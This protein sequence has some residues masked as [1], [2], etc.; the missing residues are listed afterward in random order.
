[1]CIDMSSNISEGPDHTIKLEYNANGEKLIKI[2]ETLSNKSIL[3]TT[4]SSEGG[5]LNQRLLKSERSAR[6]YADNFVEHEGL[7]PR[8]GV[9][10]DI[11]L[12]KRCPKCGG[13]VERYSKTALKSNE[14]PIMPM[15]VCRSCGA[16]SYYMTDSYLEHLI[17]INSSLFSNIDIKAYKENSKDFINEIREHI[18]RIFAARRIFEI[19]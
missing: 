7:E 11:V 19:R 12:G 1:M 15:Y 16:K 4:F 9:Y 13:E 5:I 17:S 2:W 14:I 3:E 6:E 18:N 8:E 10:E